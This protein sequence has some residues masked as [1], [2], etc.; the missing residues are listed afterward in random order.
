MSNISTR[1]SIKLVRRF[2]TVKD[3]EIENVYIN[4]MNRLIM[5]MEVIALYSEKCIN[6]VCGYTAVF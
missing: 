6:T 3:P 2:F 1:S 5:F 4:H